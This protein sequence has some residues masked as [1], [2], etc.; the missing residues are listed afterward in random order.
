MPGLVEAASVRY[1][2]P[3]PSPADRVQDLVT[4]KV[5]REK[6]ARVIESAKGD[7][8]YSRHRPSGG[9]G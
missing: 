4:Y 2:A 1:G 7:G 6:P 3:V 9:D 8:K 5:S